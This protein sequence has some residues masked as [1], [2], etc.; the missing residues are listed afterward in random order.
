MSSSLPPIKNVV[1]LMLENRSFDNVLGALYP[2]SANFE[3]LTFT[4]SNDDI[5]GTPYTIA[6]NPNSTAIPPV[7]PGESFV[8]MA[9]QIYGNTSGTG[10]ANMSGFGL[11]YLAATSEYPAL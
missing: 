11:G 3:G 4:E 5:N 9:L 10:S 1:V 6:N 2:N 7:D 8:D